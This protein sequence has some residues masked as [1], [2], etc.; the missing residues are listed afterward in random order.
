MAVRMQVPKLGGAVR[1]LGLSMRAAQTSAGARHEGL[2]SSSEP[3]RPFQGSGPQAR[4]RT[5]LQVGG[6]GEPD[7][8]ADALDEALLDDAGDAAPL[9]H[10]RAVAQ[11]QGGAL[12][13]GAGR[14]GAGQAGRRVWHSNSAA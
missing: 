12:P 5:A 6:D 13:C 7:G 3:T 10:A 9:A 1:A 14:G 4:V 8:L 2:P 11:E